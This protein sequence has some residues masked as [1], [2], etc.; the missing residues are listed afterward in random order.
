MAFSFPRNP[1]K[2]PFHTFRGLLVQPLFFAFW[3]LSPVLHVFQLDVIHQRM[4]VLG[5]AFP[6]EQWA[7]MWVPIVF[8]GCVLLIAFVSTLWGRLFCGWVC[9]HN[10]LTEWTQT[11]RIFIGLGQKPFYLTQLEKQW[12]GF[13][14]LMGLISLLWASAI[15]YM[16][17]TLFLF[18]FV[19]V[20][21]FW[22]KL[23]TGT[24]PMIIWWGQGLLMLIGL[25]MIYAGHEFCR[26]ACPYGLSQSLSAYISTKWIPMEI[27]YKNGMDLTECKSCHACQSVCP[28]DIDPRDPENLVVGIGEGCFNCGECI[29]ACS[30]VRSAHGKGNLLRFAPPS[31]SHIGPREIAE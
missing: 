24:L 6:F 20:E 22:Q 16:I 4:I 14:L 3:F 17:S 9:P 5:Q 19:P 10:T 13:R 1:L 11:V 29:D 15:T 23:Q 30:Y 2:Y 12:P 27:R 26:S 8:F 28:V 31:R 18:Y 7:M 21:W 25:F